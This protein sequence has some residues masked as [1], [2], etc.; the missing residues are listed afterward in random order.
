M[1][2]KEFVKVGVIGCGWITGE[3]K[4]LSKVVG[5]IK[6]VAAMDL[7]LEKAI[8]VGGKT[9]AYTDLD[10]MYKNEDLDAVYIATPHSLHKPMIKQAF[11]EGKHVHCEKPVGISVEDCREIKQLDEKYSNLKLGFNYNFRYDH[12]C[13]RLASGIQNGHLGKVYYAN[14]NVFF[15]RKMDY[16]NKGPWRTKFAT[17]GGG[18]LLIH[19]SHL[20]DIMLWAMGEPTN[21]MGK[22]DTMKFKDLEVED[23]GFGIVEF[24]SGAYAQINDSMFIHPKMRKLNDTVE[25]KIFGEKGRCYYRGPWPFSSLEWK[26]VKKFKVKKNTKGIAHFGRSMKAFGNWILEDTPYLNTIEESSR[27]LRLISALYNS[28]KSGKKE[29]VEKL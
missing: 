5:N 28:S 15:S 22:I 7:Q 13:Y 14:C 2:E 27:P 17:A 29:P 26:G 23:V 9:H 12:K 16:F 19:G 3:Y 18:T 10:K 4:L 8:K 25:L 20:I 21:V 24:E 11:E 1:G 6:I